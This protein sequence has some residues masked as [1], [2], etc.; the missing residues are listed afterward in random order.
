[1]A[2]DG[3]H[4]QSIFGTLFSKYI[5]HILEKIFFSLDYESY[6]YCLEVSNEWKGVLT[7]ERYKAKG[8][9]VFKEE[10]LEDEK[11]LCIA[12][13]Q[14]SEDEVRMLLSS[15]MVNVIGEDNCLQTPLNWA[16]KRGHKEMTQLLIQCGGD[17]NVADYDGDTP[18]HDAASK[19][20]KEVVQLLIEHGA[21]PNVPDIDGLT[22]LYWVAYRDH[23]EMS[24][25][26]I[27]CGA[28]PNVADKHGGTPLNWAAYWGHKEVV[29]LLI[30]CGAGVNLASEHGQTPL[31][32]AAQRGHKEVAKLL[33]EHGADMDMADED[34]NTPGHY[35]DWP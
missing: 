26:L 17:P 23:K 7:S 24:Q 9:S 4:C 34:G 12:A 16:A 29:Q 1:M 27:R 3:F 19:G 18:L 22:P 15:G 31:Y 10:I 33:I 2:S 21:D 14:G 30:E 6:K 32:S 28:D 5:P 13:E 25:L 20:H 8:K 35:M 11:K